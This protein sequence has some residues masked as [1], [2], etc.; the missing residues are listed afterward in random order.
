MTQEF[1]TFAAAQAHLNIREIKEMGDATTEVVLT[2]LDHM[3]WKPM[4]IR[5][6]AMQVLT[7]KESRKHLAENVSMSISKIKAV[8]KSAVN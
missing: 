8:L 3:V 6:K 1:S 7:N 5:L 2:A 4:P